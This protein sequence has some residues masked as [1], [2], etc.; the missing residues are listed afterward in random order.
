VKKRQ[1]LSDR[2]EVAKHLHEHITVTHAEIDAFVRDDDVTRLLVLAEL[3]ARS[4][5]LE[6]SLVL[7]LEPA[8]VAV[9]AVMLSRVP[10]ASGGLFAKSGWVNTVAFGVVCLVLAVVVVALLVP[11]VWHAVK[12]S[13]DRVRAAVWVAAYKE[14]LAE[15]ASARPWSRWF[16]R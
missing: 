4:A 11:S 1:P 13:C 7:T 9:F 3:R 14:A 12:G 8:A 5:D 16:P 15:R 2:P 10:V 6:T